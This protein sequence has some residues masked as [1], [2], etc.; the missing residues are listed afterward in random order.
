MYKCTNDG[1]ASMPDSLQVDTFA[2]IT[3]ALSRYMQSDFISRSCKVFR[4]TAKHAIKEVMVSAFGNHRCH[5]TAA[6][7]FPAATWDRHTACGLMTR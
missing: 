7:A 5:N 6:S 2:A 1:K 4:V 3:K